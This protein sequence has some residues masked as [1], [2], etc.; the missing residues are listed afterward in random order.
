MLIF[1]ALGAGAFALFRQ[2]VG[3]EPSPVKDLAQEFADLYRED[4]TESPR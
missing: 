1:L 2:A 3:E 4:K